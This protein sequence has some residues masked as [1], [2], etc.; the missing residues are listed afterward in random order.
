MSARH[1]K[2]QRMN[3][4]L[5]SRTFILS[6]RTSVPVYPVYNQTDIAYHSAKWLKGVPRMPSTHAEIHRSFVTAKPSIDYDFI[7]DSLGL[8]LNL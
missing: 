8:Q 5:V 3:I 4:N 6:H 1:S 7:T 2:L